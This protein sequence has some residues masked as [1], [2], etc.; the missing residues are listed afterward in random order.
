MDSTCFPA[1][2]TSYVLLFACR[3][4]QDQD[5]RLAHALNK[6][7]ALPS[8]PEDEHLFDSGA[9]AVAS[10]RPS[11]AVTASRAG[12]GASGARAVG[13]LEGF[14]SSAGMNP[15]ARGGGG[16]PSSAFSVSVG[17][18]S[19]MTES[20]WDVDSDLKAGLMGSSNTPPGTKLPLGLAVSDSS[21][22]WQ[23]PFL[24]AAQAGAGKGAGLGLQPLA[25][26]KLT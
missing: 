10:P 24:A 12:P 21:V 7:A 19:G 9:N 23:D 4:P 22:A 26:L 13:M 15:S 25:G 3:V 6:A 17:A 11:A 14:G 5:Q 18:L 16:R 2:W 8:T 20:S 1:A